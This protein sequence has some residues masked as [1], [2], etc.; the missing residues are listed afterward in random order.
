MAQEE[1]SCTNYIYYLTHKFPND[2]RNLKKK[3]NK[4]VTKFRGRKISVFGI[5]GIKNF[6]FLKIASKVW[7]LN[8]FKLPSYLVLAYCISF[9][10][11]YETFR[12]KVPLLIQISNKVVFHRKVPPVLFKEFS[13]L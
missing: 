7:I 1:S 13:A 11:N 3:M 5:F 8:R 12:K 9:A 6:S 10:N 4:L 2:Q